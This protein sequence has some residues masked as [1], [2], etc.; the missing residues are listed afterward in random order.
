VKTLGQGQLVGMASVYVNI[1]FSDQASG[2][3]RSS[4][5]QTCSLAVITEAKKETVESSAIRRK[6]EKEI[7]MFPENVLLTLEQCSII[8]FL[9]LPCAYIHEYTRF[10]FLQVLCH[11]IYFPP[12]FHAHMISNLYFNCFFPCKVLLFPFLLELY[13]HNL[14]LPFL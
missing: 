5:L 9:V 11:A 10:D 6:K 1:Q 14:A 4:S 7:L 8:L 13:L 3:C 2:V 12:K